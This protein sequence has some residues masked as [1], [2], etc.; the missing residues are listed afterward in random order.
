L[1]YFIDSNVVIGYYFQYADHWGPDALKVFSS[2]KQ[3]HSGSSVKEE[4][5]GCDEKSGRCN[6]IK[7]EV[8]RNFSQA[9]TILIKTQSPLELIGTAIDNKWRIVNIIQDMILQYESDIESFVTD[10][11]NAKWK[12]EADCNDRCDELHNGNTVIF[13]TRSE[14]YTNIYRILEREISD[15]ADIEVIL[16]AHHVECEGTNVLFISGDY[17]HIIPKIPFILENTLLQHIVPLGSFV[18]NT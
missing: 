4:C 3:I 9:V 11:K 6:T 16:D 10:L 2:D 8:L 14:A 13:H 17:D 12:F 5:F 1:N 7:N 15:I 18:K